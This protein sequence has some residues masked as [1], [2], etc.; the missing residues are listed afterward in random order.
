[1]LNFRIKL[2]AAFL[3]AVVLPLLVTNYLESQEAK[4]YASKSFENGFQ[5]DVKQIEDRVSLIFSQY[6]NNVG[7]VSGDY[8]FQSVK[9]NLTK[10]LE[11]N[12]VQMQPLLGSE[13][14][15]RLFNL[16]QTLS[17]NYP[18]LAYAYMGTEEGGYTQWPLGSTEKNYDPRTR[19]WYKTGLAAGGEVVRTPTYYWKPDNTALISTV[20]LIKDDED[21]NIG[22]FG[23]DITLKG[24]TKMLRD[25]DFGQDA[26]IIVVEQKGRILADTLE[27]NNVFGFIEDISGGSLLSAMSSPL[28]QAPN[29]YVDINNKEYLVT[30]YY[31]DY[32]DWSFIGLIPRASIE[33]NVANL[34]SKMNLVMMISII[35][36]GLVAVVFSRFISNTIERKQRLL[37]LAKNQAEQANLA[38]S[39][40]LANMSHEIRTPLNGIIGM[41][42]LLSQTELNPLQK[43]KVA[44]IYNSGNLLMEIISDILDFSKI[45]AEKLLLHP[46]ET[47]LAT[48]FSNV[49]LSHYGNACRKGL[50]LV[51]DTTELDNLT[52]I[53]DDIRLTQII[54]NLLSN[55]IKFTD[56]GEVK[57]SC[58][59]EFVGDNAAN[60]EVCISDT[61][62]GIESS[63]QKHIFNSFEQADSSTT[64]EYG[65]TG[66][67][68]SLCK[69]L[70]ELMD[71]RLIIKSKVGKGSKFKFVLKV[72]LAESRNTVPVIPELENKN[73]VI[74]IQNETS[75]KVANHYFRQQGA[76][77][78]FFLSELDAKHFIG[79]NRP[80]DFQIDY[81]IVDEKQ[82][83]GSGLNFIMSVNNVIPESCARILICDQYP[84]D[85]L[86]FTTHH[87]TRVILKPLCIS[88]LVAAFEMEPI[89]SIALHDEIQLK[90]DELKF[91][92]TD[93]F[94]QKKILVV[95]DNDINYLVAER[96]LKSL[97][98]CA[99]RAERGE[100][101]VAMF[102]QHP[103]ELILMD[104]MLPGM[105][106]YDATRCIRDVELLKKLKPSY[107][108]ALTADVSKE[109]KQRCL[110]AGMDDYMSKPFDF[111]VLADMIKQVLG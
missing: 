66:L 10:Y 107:I 53:I 87:I 71:S 101:A 7:Y 75:L 15:V 29:Q 14:E 86:L 40:F 70:L 2:I 76:N 82:E 98:L 67:G 79:A 25:L 59:V 19:P 73:V 34:T 30:Q 100:E 4:A 54:G 26:R 36:F 49:A 27:E 90:A 103:F 108:I 62:I 93:S 35:I 11:S 51:V 65:G 48:L 13:E 99:V 20:R 46:V 9:G 17:T 78:S 60:L 63:K 102:E 52:A 56:A 24:F 84:E 61:G 8:R 42:Q 50:E 106:G 18:K 72:E 89:G 31:S 47:N 39:E 80:A 77:V 64:R 28:A 91:H 6:K 37:E 104:C 92:E 81:L 43:Q 57:L 22:V 33:E 83:R 110:H 38:K 3:I 45:E 97:D 96:F 68:L 44:T 94:E 12:A 105:D 88:Q 5:K 58:A 21:N 109:N 95:E 55:A 111:K 16:F 85:G 1:M 74:V 32:L 41:G 23:M 69:S